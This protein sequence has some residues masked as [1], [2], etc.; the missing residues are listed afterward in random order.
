MVS[1]LTIRVTKDTRDSLAGLVTTVAMEF[2]DLV[3]RMVSMDAMVP[4]VQRERLERQ[5]FMDPEVCRV[6]LVSKVLAE[7]L[8]KVA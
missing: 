4:T 7:R 8:A 1:E 6:C 5:V 2:K 3:V